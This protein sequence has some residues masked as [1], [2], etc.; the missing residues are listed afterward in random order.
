MIYSWS[1]GN[2][3]G[4][5]KKKVTNGI[6]LI[7]QCAGNVH[8]KTSPS[9]LIANPGQVLGPNLYTTEEAPLYRRGLLSKYGILRCAIC[10]KY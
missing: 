5:T 4:E 6:L 2:T 9:E 3:G 8:S 7:G 10:A 1:A